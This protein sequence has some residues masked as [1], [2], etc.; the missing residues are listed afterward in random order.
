MSDAVYECN[1]VGRELREFEER[2]GAKVAHVVFVD[3]KE[4][5]FH[6][7]SDM[8]RFIDLFHQ[9]LI[10]NLFV[11]RDVETEWRGTLSTLVIGRE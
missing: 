11:G 4:Q 9:G 6:R 10:D 7:Q 3:G 2:S 8:K 1:L 5:W